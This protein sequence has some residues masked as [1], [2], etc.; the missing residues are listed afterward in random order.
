M[1]QL[2]FQSTQG[3]SVTFTG[4]VTS[5]FYNVVVPASDGTLLYSDASNNV[6]V[7]NLT[8]TGTSSFSGTSTFANAVSFNSFTCSQDASFTGTGEIKLPSGTTGQ[9]SATPTAGMIRYNSSTGQFEGYSTTWGQLGGGATGGGGDAVF[10]ENSVIV[11]TS[12]T[13]TT[14]KNA[15]S[16]GPITIN[17]GAIITVPSGQRW[18]VL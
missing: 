8:V 11:T 5:S 18:V 3:G 10:V 2:V 9:R 1:S 6:S 16:V 13:L 12:Y 14:G 4:P 7:A 17:S 15:E